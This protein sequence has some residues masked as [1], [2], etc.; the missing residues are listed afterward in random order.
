LN[1]LLIPTWGLWGATI[2]TIIGYAVQPLLLYPLAQ[3]R[4][5]IPYPLPKLLAAIG[6]QLGVMV[7]GALLPPMYFPIRVA[8]KLLLFAILPVSFIV[9]GLISRFELEQGF[10]F[11]RHR[12][13]L[14]MARVSGG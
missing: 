11:V 4:Y 2:A 1:F 14:A 6:I 5:A 7:I 12:W 3:K 10:L 9:L 13:R 8:L